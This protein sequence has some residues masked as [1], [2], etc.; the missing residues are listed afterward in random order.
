MNTKLIEARENVTKA[1]EALRRGDKEIAR[2]LG[3]KAA[4]LVPDFEDAWLVLTAA[5]SNHEDALAY[6]QKALEL[7]PESV[8]A[9]KAVEWAQG[10]LRQAQA[11]PEP[12]RG[13]ETG[14]ARARAEMS[15]QSAA[16]VVQPVKREVEKSPPPV[17]KKS[18]QRIWT[19]AGILLLGL[20]ICIALGIAIWSV[21]N[22]PVFA[23]FLS[24]NNRAPVQENH[25][26]QVNIPKPSVTPIDVSAFAP[27]P[28]SAVT[29]PE[30]VAN[31]ALT[32]TP[33][34]V[35]T[36]APTDPPTSIPTEAPTVIPEATETPGVMAMD[37]VVNTPTSAYVPPAN[38]PAV[39]ASG[40]G[41]GGARWI[42]VDLSTQSVYAYQGDTVV[43]SFIVSTGTSYTPTVTGKFKIWIKFKSTTMSG[44]GY[45]LPNVPYAMYF[46]KGYGLHGTY[47]HNNFG[48]PMSHGC[49]NLRTSDAEWLYYWAP[50]GTVVNVHY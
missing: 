29:L 33:T 8:R 24:S 20:L 6:A 16:P 39:V 12:I 48:T 30:A 35:P 46:Y 22:T 17:A 50:E 28:T 1:R 38:A 40:N 9:R 27:Q 5:D 37:I 19:Y 25:W 41:K 31:D 2:D 18:N 44:P 11:R 23:A 14:D 49:V 21:L 43:N 7:N 34:D 4:L 45:Y 13:I 26:A 42:D 32:S 10:K 3:E 47:W 15:V 36:L